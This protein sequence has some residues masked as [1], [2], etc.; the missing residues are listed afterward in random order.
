M[1]DNKSNQ[2]KSI[3]EDEIAFAPV[4]LY[5]TLQYCVVCD[6]IWHRIFIQTN[7]ENTSAMRDKMYQ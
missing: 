3:L 2:I 6:S 7:H 4:Q 5:I 1:D